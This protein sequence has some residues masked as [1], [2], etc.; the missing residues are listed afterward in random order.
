MSGDNTRMQ[1][2]PVGGDPVSDAEYERLFGAGSTLLTSRAGKKVM[3]EAFAKQIK[4]AK[5]NYVGYS[6]RFIG[7]TDSIKQKELRFDGTETVAG[8]IGGDFDKGFPTKWDLIQ[9]TKKRNARISLA[10]EE[11][12][13]NKNRKKRKKRKKSNSVRKRK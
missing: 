4:D 9:D 1:I 8:E 12:T 6:S 11:A 13:R 3:S 7:A 2:T 5:T 10:K